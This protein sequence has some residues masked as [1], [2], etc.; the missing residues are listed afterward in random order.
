VCEGAAPVCLCNIPAAVLVFLGY[1]VTRANADISITGRPG[2]LND[3]SVLKG[4]VG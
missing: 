1:E 4:G 2:A 3:I